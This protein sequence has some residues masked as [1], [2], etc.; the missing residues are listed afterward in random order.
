MEN[1]LR[2]VELRPNVLYLQYKAKPQVGL[3][4]IFQMRDSFRDEVSGFVNRSKGNT[5]GEY[6]LLLF[7]KFRGSLSIQ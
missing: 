4:T 1:L 2:T 7:R 3:H 5:V 6:Q